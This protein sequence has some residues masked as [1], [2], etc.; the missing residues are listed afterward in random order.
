MRTW[1]GVRYSSMQFHPVTSGVLV[2]DESIG[3]IIRKKEL[4]MLGNA[5]VNESGGRSEGR[6]EGTALSFSQRTQGSP[7]FQ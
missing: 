1:E 7:L 2:F 6:T 4:V 3:K 5:D